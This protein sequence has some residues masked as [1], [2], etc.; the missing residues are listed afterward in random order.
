VR[1]PVSLFGTMDYGRLETAHTRTLGWLLD[2]GKEHGF[3]DKLI[4]ALLRHLAAPDR[5]ESVRVERVRSEYPIAGAAPERGRLDV[6]A[7]GQWGGSD[8]HLQ[9]WILVI[10]AKIGA[11]EGEGQL[12]KYENWL[13]PE[14]GNR[15]VLR[16]L[17]T[18]DARNAVSGKKDWKRLSYLDL[19][20]VFRGV[21]GQLSHAPG[22][23]FLRYYLAGV[24]RD[25]CG[26]PL[27]VA[28]H[29]RNPYALVAY[30]KAARGPEPEDVT[31][32]RTR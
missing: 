13:P 24:L 11:D 22:Y 8:A 6:L 12:E 23:H 29:P 2:P 31:H 26:W 32:A 7:L 19:V 5:I 20:R 25:V 30:L 16:V 9:S 15:K 28:D 3:G 10:E 18:P 1:C 27:P 17:L 4:S 21:Y 14:A